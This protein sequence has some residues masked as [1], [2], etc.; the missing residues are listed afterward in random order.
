MREAAKF[1]QEYLSKHSDIEPINYLNYV[2]NL[3]YFEDLL[4]KKSIWLLEP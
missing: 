3:W 2:N 1:Y 4:Q